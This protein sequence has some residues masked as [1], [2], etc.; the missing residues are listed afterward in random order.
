[1]AELSTPFN[2]ARLKFARARLGRSR[3]QL[4]RDT[5]VPERSLAGYELGDHI[6]PAETA[7]VLAA[8]LGVP[9]E[10]MFADELEQLPKRLPSFRAASKLTSGQEQAALS[11]GVLSIELNRWLEQRLRLPDVSVPRYER[12]AADPVGA[13][14]RLRLEWELGHAPIRNMVHLLEG[15]GVRVFSLPERLADVDAF[16]FWWQSTPYV[17][18]NTRKS[19]ERGRFDA[20]HELGHLVMHGDHDRPPGREG[21]QEANRFAAAL[22]MPEDDVLAAG[23][24]NAGVEQVLKAKMRWGVAAMALTYRLHELGVTTDWVYTSTCRRLAQMGY[25][26]AEPDGG[27]RET[28]RLLEKSL[29]A[30]RE[31]NLTVAHI[32]RDLH[33]LPDAL[34]ELIFGLTLTPVAGG[35]QTAPAPRPTLRL[36]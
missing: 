29:T 23:L 8:A 14:R 28:S 7:Q 17:L 33:M 27:M 1:M 36:V 18:L 31:R 4:S 12:G 22:L 32:A 10:F 2:P 6:P 9:V 24:R 5:G 20:A 19:A 16:S 11:S 15:H 13:A 25:R 35:Q 30:L 21:E 3:V 34:R 26:S